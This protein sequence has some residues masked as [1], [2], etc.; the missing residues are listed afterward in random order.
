MYFKNWAFELM[1][2][3]FSC[4]FRKTANIYGKNGRT[5]HSTQLNFK[6]NA[7]FLKLYLLKFHVRVEKAMKYE[8]FLVKITHVIERCCN[9]KLC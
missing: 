6:V 3:L 5:K 9:V 7:A 1:G 2:L 4:V 8:T